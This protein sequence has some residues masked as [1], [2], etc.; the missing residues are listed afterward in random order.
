MDLN[1]LGNRQPVEQA[2]GLLNRVIAILDSEN[3]AVAAAKVDEARCA[4]RR[5]G[6]ERDDENDPC[7]ATNIRLVR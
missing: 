7:H 2:L 3:M 4:I 1:V 5:A 6:Q